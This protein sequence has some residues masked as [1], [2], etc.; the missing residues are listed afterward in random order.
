[1]SG[2]RVRLDPTNPGQFFACCGL[3]E[4][5][6]RAWCG[7]EACF[8]D[9]G[10]AFRV[11]PLAPGAPDAHARGLL[12]ALRTAPL[13]NPRVSR[14]RLDALQKRI[15]EA[16]KAARKG[17]G[18]PAL[19]ELQR[20]EGEEQA[21]FDAAWDEAKD[22]A[23]R[24]GAPFDMDV[25]WHLD[26]LS[27]GSRYKTWAGQ[28]T[29]TDIA[30]KLKLATDAALIDVAG[31]DWLAASFPCAG[32]LNLDAVGAA[33]DIDVG[34]SFDPL[35][36]ESVNRRGL[37]ELLAFLGLQRFRPVETKGENRHRYAIWFNPLSPEIAKVAAAGMLAPRQCRVFE[38]RLLYRTKYLK[39]F[40][41]ALPKGNQE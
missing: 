27:G 17:D 40:L 36:I 7:A 5:A 9:G 2:L 6:D 32:S 8:E 16:K 22:G 1:M 24:L 25:D 29:I 37:I 33:S 11:M 31:E 14:A 3:L 41:P 21:K 13:V 34:F 38:F 4:L 15:A 26:D 10:G 28:Q 30:G 23:L 39:S 35:G 19:A 12:D 18:G 20:E